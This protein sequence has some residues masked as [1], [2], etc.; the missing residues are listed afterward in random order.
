MLH[1]RKLAEDDLADRTVDAGKKNKIKW[2]VT[3]E[4]WITFLWADQSAKR[5]GPWPI[6]FF[7]YDFA[8]GRL[9]RSDCRS[10][11]SNR[12][13]PCERMMLCV[14]WLKKRNRSSYET[15]R[16]SLSNWS[17][18]P[19]THLFLPPIQHSHY[20]KVRSPIFLL[21]SYRSNFCF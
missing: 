2:S 16:R 12:T 19:N 8:V 10:P 21:L 20:Q 1:Q 7:G 15:R 14:E 3:W 13:L 9:T 6:E 18:F 4:G 11:I 17:R 5:E